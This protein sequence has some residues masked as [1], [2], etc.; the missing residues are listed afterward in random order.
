VD[1]SDAIA[2]A[3]AGNPV[4]ELGRLAIKNDELWQYR[5]PRLCLREGMV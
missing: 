1:L 3:G 4:A 2:P 5:Q